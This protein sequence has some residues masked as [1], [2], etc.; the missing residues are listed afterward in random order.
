MDKFSF[1]C[2]S[3]NN[4]EKRRARKQQFMLSL[5]KLDDVKMVI[6]IE[7]PVNFFRLIFVPA[8]S[9]EERERRARAVFARM[10]RVSSKLLLFTPVFYIP[11]AF[12]CQK[13]YD[14]NLF[15]EFVILRSKFRLLA[16][17]DVILWLYQPLD[18]R[19]LSWFKERIVSVFDWAEEW[20][21]YFK[22][23]DREK[24]KDVLRFEEEIISNADIVFVVSQE[25]LRRAKE[26]N[27]NSYYLTDGTDYEAFQ[28]AGDR[29]PD[30]IRQIAGPILGYLG[31]VA[32]R[33]DLGLVEFIARRLPHVSIVF[34]GNILMDISS[35]KHL[36]NIYFLGGKAYGDLGGYT[37]QFDVCIVPYEPES[38]AYTF[39]TKIYD[40]LATGKPI[41]STG[42]RGM[43]E[44]SDYVYIGQSN[45]D[46]VNKIEI[47][48]R[49]SDAG[50]PKKRQEIARK[51]SWSVRA[52][53]IVEYINSQR[54]HKM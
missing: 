46:F 52:E 12:R 5:S 16:L 32:E 37:R 3:I 29:V 8:R 2:F 14:I 10:E 1:V 22:E 53:E 43:D 44:F 36:K 51:N 11:F 9:Q 30:D 54:S 41:V 48:L 49:E 23:F 28:A 6:Y 7:P 31:N 38:C 25:L 39:P 27:K 15:I 13:I 20:S 34:V 40:Y 4:W 26:Y 21:E 50:L 24:Q 42:V 35:L 47:A 19:L 18:H 33:V 17:N 45:E